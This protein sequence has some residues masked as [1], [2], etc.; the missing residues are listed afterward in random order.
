MR[1]LV[2][3]MR[4]LLGEATKPAGVSLDDVAAFVKKTDSYLELDERTL[5]LLLYRT[6][7]NGDVGEEEPGEQDI[8]EVQRVM[9]LLR[10]QF[11]RGVKVGMEKVGEWVHLEVVVES[12]RVDEKPLDREEEK[13][14]ARANVFMMDVEMDGGTL[15][16]AIDKLNS[17]EGKLSPSEARV[18]L[19]W[20]DA[21]AP[22][23]Y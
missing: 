15:S 7:E 6:R 17:K 20:F 5:K 21:T 11:P 3:R 4:G 19:R 13:R 8:R 16:P 18:V 2:D 9:K 22:G 23:T 12:K 10:A 14:L 1:D